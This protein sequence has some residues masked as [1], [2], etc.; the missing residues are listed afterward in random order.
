[1]L[2][3]Q[4]SPKS[5]LYFAFCLFFLFPVLQSLLELQSFLT[6]TKL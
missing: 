5:Q 2:L 3:R 6:G 1:M 4:I